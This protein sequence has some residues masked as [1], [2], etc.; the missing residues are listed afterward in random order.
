MEL[1]DVREMNCTAATQLSIVYPR[2]LRKKFKMRV[3]GLGRIGGARVGLPYYTLQ[4]E[5]TE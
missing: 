1:N 5:Q 2:E 3:R 4:C